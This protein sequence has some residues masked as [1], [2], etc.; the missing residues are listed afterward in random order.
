VRGTQDAVLSKDLDAV[1]TSWNPAAE[2]LY[3]FSAEE[4]VGQHVSFLMPEERKHEEREILE[5]VCRGERL[6]TYETQRAHR[7]PG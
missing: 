3:G 7:L 6:E 2:L 5:R 1:I 4:A